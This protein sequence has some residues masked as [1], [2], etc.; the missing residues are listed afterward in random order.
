MFKD[1]LLNIVQIMNTLPT[2]GVLF[3]LYILSIAFM[4]SFHKLFGSLGLKLFMTLGIVLVNIKVLKGMKLD[5]F[6]E[7]IVMGTVLMGSVFLATDILAEYYGLKD[8]KQGIWMSFLGILFVAVMMLVTLG[9]APVNLGDFPQCEDMVLAHHAMERL[10]LPTP[11]ILL[12]S[13]ISYLISQYVDVTTFLQM[14]FWTN[15]RYLWIR[16]AT[17]TILSAF[18]DNCIF[19]FLAWK[20]FHPIAMSNGQFIQSYILGAFLLRLCVAALNVPVIYWVRR[21]KKDYFS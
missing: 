2:E 6:P 20:I 16:T 19:S 15:G 7:P 14:K 1:S 8:A 9:V 4:L 5:C 17:A 3:L 12:A 18:I 10:F 13:L 21:Q 11:A